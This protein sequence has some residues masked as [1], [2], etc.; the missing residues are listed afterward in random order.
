MLKKFSKLIFNL[1][2]LLDKI[3]FFLFDNRILFWFNDFINNNF[4][5]EFKLNKEKIIFFTPNFLTYW[6]SKNFLKKEPETID[7]IDDFD[8]NSD[9]NFL[10][11]GSNIGIFSLYAA[12]KFK[13]KINVYSLEPSTSNLRVL[14]RNIFKNELNNIKILPFAL[15]DEKKFQNFYESEFSEGSGLHNFGT[16]KDFQNNDLNIKNTYAIFGYS[17]DKMIEDEIIKTPNYIKID[18]DGIEKVVIKGCKN[19]LKNESLKSICIEIN[20]NLIESKNYII[21]IMKKSGFSKFEKKNNPSFI[22]SDDLK[23]TFNYFFS[24]G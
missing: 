3:I 8:K 7:W 6:R 16:K 9:I 15:S 11:I 20:E 21:D 12:K 10:D 14:S 19:T 22:L 5:S 23:N 13:N 18:V 4:Y 2:S 24:R 17:V 1:I